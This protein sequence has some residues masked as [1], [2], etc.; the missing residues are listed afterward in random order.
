M[1]QFWTR[2]PSGL[3][4]RLATA[5]HARGEASVGHP[6]VHAEIGIADLVPPVISA[7]TI[8]IPRRRKWLGSCFSEMKRKSSFC[9]VF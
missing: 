4:A 3:V 5:C 7:T 9:M 1:H 6:V 8:A 2:L